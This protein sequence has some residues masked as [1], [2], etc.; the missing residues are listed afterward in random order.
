YPLAPDPDSPWPH[1]HYGESKGAER[2]TSLPTPAHQSR[3]EWDYRLQ[4]ERLR[5][6][7]AGG[8]RDEALQGVDVRLDGVALSLPVLP[9]TLQ[10]DHRSLKPTS[11]VAWTREVIHDERV[12]LLT[13]DLT[14]VPKDR[15][16]PYDRV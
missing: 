11:A 12:W 10:M 3:R 4:K 6:A 5:T 14:W 8:P 2:Y 7:R 1:P 9:R 16:V 15:I 13:E